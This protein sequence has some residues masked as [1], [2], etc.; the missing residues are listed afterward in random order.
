MEFRNPQV[1]ILHQYRNLAGGNPFAA[2]VFGLLFLV[3]LLP[4][5]ALVLLFGAVLV[6]LTVIR[7]LVAKLTG[8]APTP[9]GFRSGG[10]QGPARGP[11]DGSDDPGGRG[12]GAGTVLDVEAT[13]RSK[14]D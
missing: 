5:L 4:V 14:P 13:V 12:A 2:F 6:V 7:L 3:M 9:R 10:G 1:R 11:A 8:R